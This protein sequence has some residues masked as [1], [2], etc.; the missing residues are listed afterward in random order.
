MWPSYKDEFC[1]DMIMQMYQVKAA[2][3]M[4]FAEI[5]ACHLVLIHLQALCAI[6]DI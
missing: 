1:K 4:D 3:P 6:S 5:H 2:A